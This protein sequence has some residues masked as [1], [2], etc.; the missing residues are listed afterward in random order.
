MTKEEA[1]K[2]TDDISSKL[3]TCKGKFEFTLNNGQ[4]E[5]VKILSIS[6]NL[7]YDDYT[8]KLLT[9]KNDINDITTYNIFDIKSAICS[10]N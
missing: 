5:N 10:T 9:F 6:T 2:L 8:C 7:T 3:S 1:I 4:T